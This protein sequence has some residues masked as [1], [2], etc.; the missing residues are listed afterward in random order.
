MGVLPTLE[1]QRHP[2]ASAAAQRRRLATVPLSR[3]FEQALAEAGL[4]PLRARA[5]EVLQVNLGKR[6]NQ[7]CH[8]CHVDA[9]PDRTEM[10]SCEMLDACLQVLEAAA[11]PTLDITGGAPELHP[12][13]RRL[14]E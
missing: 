3:S 6:C 13:F 14:V 4:A 5:I 10:M 12:E 2:L 8:H 9:G 11:I 1:K 7:T